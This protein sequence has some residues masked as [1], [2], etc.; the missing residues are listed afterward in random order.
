[1]EDEMRWLI[2]IQL[3]AGFV[4]AFLG[5]IIMF[6]MYE[7]WLGLGITLVGFYAVI[8]AIHRESDATSN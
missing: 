6:H 2:L 5:V 4:L 7:V 1:M 8:R 3:L